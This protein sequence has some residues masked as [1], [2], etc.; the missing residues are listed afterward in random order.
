MATKQQVK[1]LGF[2][3]DIRETRLQRLLSE[4][5]VALECAVAEL[6]TAEQWAIR[7]QHELSEAAN[8]FGKCP[9]NETVRIWYDLCKQ[10]LLTANQAVE[11]AKLDHEEALTQLGAAQRDVR[12]IRERSKYIVSLN[13][14]LRKVEIRR[15][16]MKS[17]EEFSV[18]QTISI[19]TNTG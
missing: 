1:M 18:Q 6:R 4:A 7:R 8:D 16:D 13:R 15:A 5:M 10:R 12:K 14:S 3:T 17:D 2:V 9:Q 11:A 19:F